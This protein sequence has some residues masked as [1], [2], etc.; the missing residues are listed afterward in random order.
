MHHQLNFLH[1]AIHS[2]GYVF[3]SARSR[4]LLSLVGLLCFQVDLFGVGYYAEVVRDSLFRLPAKFR[5]PSRT[6]GGEP[7]LLGI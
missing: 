4:S 1:A 2:T 6:L 5:H 3:F 7:R